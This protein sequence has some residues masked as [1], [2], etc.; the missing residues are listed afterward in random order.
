MWEDV[1]VAF[2]AIGFLFG[3]LSMSLGLIGTFMPRQGWL[4]P[5]FR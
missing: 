3:L 5:H 1:T 4:P 2:C